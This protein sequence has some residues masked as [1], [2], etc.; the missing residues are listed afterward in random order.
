MEIY[1]SYGQD[2]YYIKNKYKQKRRA[3]FYDLK[4]D[5]LGSYTTDKIYLDPSDKIINLYPKSDRYRWTWKDWK[6]D[7]PP[8]SKTKHRARNMGRNKGWVGGPRCTVTMNHQIRFD[9]MQD[10]RGYS[11]F[12]L[13][14]SYKD[15]S[16]KKKV[17]DKTKSRV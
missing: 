13:I 16:L 17:I 1:K 9:A 4:I 5:E 15:N 10:I 14:Y 6:Y 12:L 7:G 8:S 2:K 3:K 11:D